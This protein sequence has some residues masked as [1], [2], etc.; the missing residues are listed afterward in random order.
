[1]LQWEHANAPAVAVSKNLALVYYFLRWAPL[2]VYASFVDEL[3][4]L[5]HHKLLEPLTAVSQ[6]ASKINFFS[7]VLLE[8]A[9]VNEGRTGADATGGG[10]G[11]SATLPYDLETL[12]RVVS[13]TTLWVFSKETRQWLRSF[14]QQHA[15]SVLDK[16]ALRASYLVFLRELE[17][18][19][20]EQVFAATALHNLAKVAE[21]VI[22]AVYSYEYFHNRRSCVRDILSGSRFSGWNTFV[23]QMR[24]TY[25]GVSDS[26]AIQRHSGLSFDRTHPARNS[27]EADWNAEWLLDMED[28]IWKPSESMSNSE[29]DEDVLG[30]SLLTMFE[31]ISQMVRL[32][33]AMDTH[34]CTLSIR[35]TQGISGGLDCMRVVL[36]GKSRVFCLFPNGVTSGVEAGACGDYIGE[37]RVEDSKQLVVYLQIFNWTVHAQGPSYKVRTRIEC[38]QNRRLSVSGDIMETTAPASFTPEETPYLGEMTLRGKRKAVEKAHARQYHGNRASS[39]SASA[40]WREHGRF[41][42]SYDKV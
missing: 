24:D 26:L 30:L 32:E 33:V 37:M 34:E 19:L 21:E 20:D 27:I 13:Q 10:P 16:K 5:V 12:L 25:I 31:L 29:M 38:W 42:L 4:H 35:S 7:R 14:F 22:A 41:R 6:Q 2:H 11:H 40:S 28:A 18:R 8:Q 39:S 23:A 9:G 3:V 17:G 15:A 36:D 1:M